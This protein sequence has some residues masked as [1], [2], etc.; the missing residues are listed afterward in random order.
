VRADYWLSAAE[1]CGK[2]LAHQASTHFKPEVKTPLSLSQMLSQA[3]KLEIYPGKK[4]LEPFVADTMRDTADL[5]TAVAR[6]QT[7]IP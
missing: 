1:I 2:L 3:L 4:I 5:L 7:G 6:P